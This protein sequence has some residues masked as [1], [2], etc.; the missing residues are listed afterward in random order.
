M[1]EGSE[2]CGI[3]RRAF[4]FSTRR[5]DGLH[6]GAQLNGVRFEIPEY[7]PPTFAFKGANF[8]IDLSSCG[9]WSRP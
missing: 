3:I 2:V 6:H 4:R 8:P 9:S 1:A 7:T 5:I